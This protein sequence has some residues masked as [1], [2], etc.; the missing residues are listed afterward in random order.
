MIL[1]GT[2]DQE[3]LSTMKSYSARKP[4]FPATVCLAAATMT[5][6][7]AGAALARACA[8]NASERGDSYPQQR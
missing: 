8:A 6:L 1:L 4:Y 3:S 5:T 2:K 7:K